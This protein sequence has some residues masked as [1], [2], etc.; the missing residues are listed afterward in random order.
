MYIFKHLAVYIVCLYENSSTC[1]ACYYSSD[2]GGV[3]YPM[4]RSHWCLKFSC[5]MLKVLWL[6]IPA[7]LSWYHQHPWSMAQTLFQGNHRV[8]SELF[9]HGQWNQKVGLMK[10]S[11]SSHTT[12]VKTSDLVIRAGSK[13]WRALER[14]R[15]YGPFRLNIFFIYNMIKK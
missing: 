11:N 2:H 15:S 10:E 9:Y 4:P 5:W 6:C 7:I 13:I 12:F 14:I 1:L 8:H 3:C